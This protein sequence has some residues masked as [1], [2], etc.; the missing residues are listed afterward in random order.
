MI[1]V[2][3]FSIIAAFISFTI[4]TA[5]R[6]NQLVDIQGSS[7]VE[8]NHLFID[9]YKPLLNK[10]LEKRG[11]VS[12]ERIVFYLQ[13]VYNTINPNVLSNDEWEKAY[14]ENSSE[15]YKQMVPIKSIC[16]KLSKNSGYHGPDSLFISDNEYYYHIDLCVVNGV[17]IVDSNDYSEDFMDLP[18][19][20]PLDVS[21]ITVTSIVFERRNVD[22]GLSS[23]MQERVNFHDGWDFAVGTGTTFR[24]ACDGIITKVVNTQANDLNFS[25]QPSPKNII[26]NYI[27]VTCDNQLSVEYWHLKYNSLYK[28]LKQ[29]DHVNRGQPLAQ[30]STTGMSTNPHLHVGLRTSDETLLDF[31]SYVDFK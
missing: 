29:G 23:E 30:T 17:S 11:Y 4:S 18:Y 10:Y 20:F 27:V 6:K 14:I 24:S 15:E 13:T 26:G 8:N 2:V 3:M 28:G 31:L 7:Y 25:N 16:K 21:S 12:L 9:K 1:L 22:L 5:E 19:V